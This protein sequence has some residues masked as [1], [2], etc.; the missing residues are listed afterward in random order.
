[1]LGTESDIL[2]VNDLKSKIEFFFKKVNEFLEKYYRSDWTDHNI[3]DPG[4]LLL[5]ILCYALSDLTHRL[6]LPIEDLLFNH[7]QF[8]NIKF[9]EIFSPP[10][11]ILPTYALTELDIRKILLDIREIKNVYIQKS[12]ESEQ[13]VFYDE[14]SASLVQASTNYLVTLKGLFN[15]QLEFKETGSTDLNSNL[16]FGKKIILD[17]LIDPDRI[18]REV[19]YAFEFFWD[20]AESSWLNST[21]IMNINVDSIIEF[22]DDTSDIYEEYYAVLTISFNADEPDIQITLRIKI[23]P[24]IEKSNTSLNNAIKVSI[25]NQLKSED[26]SVV[27][28]YYSNRKE[29]ERILQK[30]KQT[31]HSNRSLCE[32]LYQFKAIHF[33]EIAIKAGIEIEPDSDPNQI[34]AEICFSIEKKFSPEVEFESLQKFYEILNISTD[35]IYEGPL[36]TS[37]FIEDQKLVKPGFNEIIYCSDLIHMISGI[38]N[39]LAINDFT[40]STYVNNSTIIADEANCV[41]LE[42][43]EKYKPKFSL[44]KSEF[45]F[46]RGGIQIEVIDELVWELL[47]RLRSHTIESSSDYKLEFAIGDKIDLTDFYSIQNE[48]PDIYGIGEKNALPSDSSVLR[49]AQANQMRG[50]LVLY[51]QILANIANQISHVSCFFSL[52]EDVS[53][54]YFPHP[55]YEIPGINDFLNVFINGNSSWEEFIADPENDYL[56]NL[57]QCVETSQLFLERRN[58][59]LDHLLARIGEK[60]SDFHHNLYLSLNPHYIREK[61][62]FFKDC[63]SQINTRNKAFNYFSDN[64]PLAYWDSDNVSGLEKRVASLL[65]LKNKNRRNLSADPNPEDMTQYFDFFEEE[66]LHGFELKG[67]EKNFY[68][69]IASLQESY[70]EARK[71]SWQS[72]QY[73]ANVLNYGIPEEYGDSI[74]VPLNHP[75]EDTVLI[76]VSKKINKNESLEDER[77]RTI[78]FGV[79]SILQIHKDGEGLFLIEHILLRPVIA[80]EPEELPPL[81]TNH[82]IQQYPQ[83]FSDPY[84]FQAAIILPSGYT[85]DFSDENAK[86]VERIWSSRLRNLS[87]RKHIEQIIN[88]ECPAH[89]LARV[90]WLDIN[91]N[92]DLDDTPSLN[93]L[94]IKYREW[95]AVKTNPQASP[96]DLTEFMKAL[97]LV[98]NKIF[99]EL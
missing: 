30:A 97:I 84:S 69:M 41:S 4:I 42:S 74:R 98:L 92:D 72:I 38:K 67:T 54:T 88:R 49:K 5:E 64:G 78:E 91:T 25:E 35:K 65:G 6:N 56:I 2:L 14:V 90:Y 29:I 11:R 37:G 95:L 83:K 80:V 77:R 62:N 81:L 44:E 12:T 87:F 48:L 59:T 16:L 13:K 45:I 52:D 71:I 66:E 75:D 17:E 10:E 19:S 79:Y 70:N 55:I 33:Q 27:C 51:D 31:F 93:N 61:I 24:G 22:R 46:Y 15:I 43:T 36:L 82:F 60:Y 32:D 23:D 50:F 26:E 1:M 28:R 8:S 89:I 34:L 63:S 40:I 7:P 18:E 85:R 68:F 57:I 86:P 94:E 58:K 20:E 53:N 99:T 3:H 76:Y 9:R 39:I 73:G 96:Q 47:K 21:S